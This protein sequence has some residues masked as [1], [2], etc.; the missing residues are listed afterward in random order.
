MNGQL[1]LLKLKRKP[2]KHR[3]KGAQ[4][5]PREPPN[6]RTRPSREGAVAWTA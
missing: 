6:E 4:T 2:A 1:P 5:P 3:R